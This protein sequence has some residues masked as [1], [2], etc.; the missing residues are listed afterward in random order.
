MSTD[1]FKLIPAAYLLL[2]RDDEILLQRR[3]GTGYQDGM[4]SLV[5]GHL[6]GDELAREAMVR[7]ANEEA[8][9]TVEP[10][11]L[12]FVHLAHRLTRDNPGQERVDIFFETRRWQGEP[13]IMEPDKSDDL[14]WFSLN[15]LP[16]E[17]IP[18]IQLVIADIGKGV[19]YSEYVA[20]PL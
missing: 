17:I 16:A 7:E 18:F 11:D 15:D 3:A 19:S 13:R 1:R 8:G 6:E 14:R 9:I 4:Y 2:R 12:K 20:E 10:D 5:S